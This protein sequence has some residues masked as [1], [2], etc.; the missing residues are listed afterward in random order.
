MSHP[1]NALRAAIA[2][3]LLGSFTC[4][5]TATATADPTGT[6]SDINALA[7]TLSKGYSLSNCTAEG[8]P[9]G[10]LAYLQCG[11]SPDSAGPALGKYFLFGNGT[12]LA[13]SFKSVIAGDTLTTCGDQQSPTSWHLGN[14]T[15]NAGSVACGTFQ[16]QAEIIWT[17]DAKNVLSLIRASNGDVPALY[18]WW[19]TNG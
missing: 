1:T 15:S 13:A 2:A 17:T 8:V 9:A 5:G 14:A 6:Q 12:D 3:A 7:G 11:Q 19:K 10:A 18:Q 4:L 16:N